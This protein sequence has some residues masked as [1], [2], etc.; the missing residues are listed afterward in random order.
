MDE[1]LR[2]FVYLTILFKKAILSTLGLDL[3]YYLMHSIYSNLF[4]IHSPYTI[5]AYYYYYCTTSYIFVA[6]NHHYNYHYRHYSVKT[7]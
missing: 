1:L 3:F 5:K 4:T 7:K 6:N 2:L